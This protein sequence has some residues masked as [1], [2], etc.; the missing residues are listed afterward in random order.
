MEIMQKVPSLQIFKKKDLE[1]LM[2]DDHLDEPCLQKLADYQGERFVL[3][4]KAD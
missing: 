2:W 3:I 4:Q 1:V